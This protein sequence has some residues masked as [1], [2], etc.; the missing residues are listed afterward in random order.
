[1]RETTQEI[2]ELFAHVIQSAV[3]NFL[4]RG[5]LAGV[6]TLR[7]TPRMASVCE[8]LLEDFTTK[9]STLI[10]DKT[11][12]FTE[13]EFCLVSSTRIFGEVFVRAYGITGRFNVDAFVKGLVHQWAPSSVYECFVLSKI[14]DNMSWH[15]DGGGKVASD[16]VVY[17]VLGPADSVSCFML[18]VVDTMRLLQVQV[19]NPSFP[20]YEEINTGL[21]KIDELKIPLEMPDLTGCEATFCGLKTK[22]ELNGIKVDIIEVHDDKQKYLVEHTSGD[23]IGKHNMV[24]PRN[25]Q[26][27]PGYCVLPDEVTCVVPCLSAAVQEAVAAEVVRCRYIWAREGDV[28]VFDGSMTH[29]VFNVASA[30]GRSQLALAVNYRGVMPLVENDMKL[31]K[32]ISL[33]FHAFD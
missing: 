9:W 12:L 7:V 21:I 23:S 28:V 16:L 22:P 15:V 17:N 26:F 3:W 33:K 14:K 31:G 32:K 29:A 13:E 19:A 24:H 10:T 20:S 11:Q 30:T 2:R 6:G 1:M 18:L 25:L 8:H 4:T 5:F 27:D